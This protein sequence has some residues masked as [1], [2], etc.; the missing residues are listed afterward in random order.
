MDL[1][2]DGTLSEIVDR[3][4]RS[5]D[6]QPRARFGTQYDPT[7]LCRFGNTTIGSMTQ[8]I[9]FDLFRYIQQALPTDQFT[10][11]PSV[12]PPRAT[13]SPRSGDP[14]HRRALESQAVAV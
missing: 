6:S 4:R 10:P 8:N 13:S 3:R 5:H 11:I 14:R 7:Y 12:A 9:T 2:G 1:S